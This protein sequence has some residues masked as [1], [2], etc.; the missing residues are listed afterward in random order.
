MIKISEKDYQKLLQDNSQQE[1]MIS[2]YEQTLEKF[3]IV[4]QSPE[5]QAALIELKRVQQ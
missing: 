4:N 5:D 2:H 3:E 1:R